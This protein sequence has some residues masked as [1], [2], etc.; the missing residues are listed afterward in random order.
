[1]V[2]PN[3]RL[4]ENGPL[5]VLSA[6]T[7]FPSREIS[8]RQAPSLAR[9]DDG[10]LLLA[11][12]LARGPVRANDGVVVLTSSDDDGLHW[13]E[14]KVHYEYPGWDCLPMGGLV[15]YSDD[16][17]RL[18]VG[19]VQ[20]DLSLPG[21]EPFT[22]FF[23]TSIDSLDGGLTWSEPGPEIRLFP[24]WTEMYGAS[25]PHILSDGRFMLA[26]I[27]TTGRDEGWQS[28]VTSSDSGGR[29]LAPPVIIAQAPDRN[30]SDTD[31]V[32]LPD[33]RFLAVI[34]EHVTRQS[35]Y[36]HSSDEGKTWSRVR[37]TGFKGANHKL[38]KLR[39]GAV[40]CAYRDED[41]GRHGVSCSM[42]EDGGHTWRLVGQLYADPHTPFH[43]PSY[44]C[45]YPDLVY[46][47]PDDLTCVLH[48]YPDAEGSIDLHLVRLRDRS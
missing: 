29:G 6:E 18:I 32:R 34:R 23:T 33:G 1:M 30:F 25:N 44:V 41:P 10:R 36:S 15:R 16:C 45:G 3:P 14:P 46:T 19:R 12:R 7:M 37:S 24:C 4:D 39:S 9:L 21:D 31:L 42:S 27:G 5:E 2:E 28:G 22:G 8:H 13:Q 43:M 40:L 20:L 26:A 47:S 11:F 17:V 38:V 35:F 48:T